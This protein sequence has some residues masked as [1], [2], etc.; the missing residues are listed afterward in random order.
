MT[1][2]RVIGRGLFIWSAA[3]LMYVAGPAT[4][5]AAP[6]LHANNDKQKDKGRWAQPSNSAPTISGVPDPTVLENRTYDFLPSAYDPDGDT[7]SFGVRNLPRWAAFDASSGRLFGTPGSGDIGLYSDIVIDVSDGQVSTE[8][9]AFAIEVVANANGAVTLSWVAPTQNEDGSP[10][11]DLAG[12]EIYW[13]PQS[14]S[15]PYSVQISNP[16]ITA[17]TLENL[18]AGTYYFA[19]KARNSQGVTSTFSGETAATIAP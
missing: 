16:G 2:G 7:L 4:P 5:W 11:L 1:Q 12:Y 6:P 18:T 10:L 19:M 9:P 14:G 8:L 17:Y 15:Y 13:G 3:L